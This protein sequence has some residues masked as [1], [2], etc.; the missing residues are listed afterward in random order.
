MRPL[1]PHQQDALKYLRHSNSGALWMQM[2]LGKTLTVVRWVDYLQLR[3]GDRRLSV[4]VVAPM[5]ALPAWEKELRTEG[6]HYLQWLLGTRAQRM[7]TLDVTSGG[8]TLFNKEGFLALPE[9]A[10]YPW[11]VVIID[12][13][14]FLKSPKSKVSKFFCRNF[15]DVPHRCVLSGCPNPESALEFFQQFKFLSGGMMG[16]DNWWSFRSR[17]FKPDYVGY[18]WEPKP[19]A[20]ALI[21]K[22]VADASFVLNREDAGYHIPKVYEQ[23]HLTLPPRLKKSYEKAEEEFVLMLD[24][25]MLDETQWLLKKFTWLRRMCG[26]WVGDTQIWKGKERELLYLLTSELSGQ[27][28]VVWFAFNKELESFHSALTDAGI[29]SAKYRGGRGAAGLRDRRA[30]L[31]KFQLGEARVLLA[32][33]SCAALGMDLSAADTAI[34]ISSPLGRELRSQSEDRILSLQKTKSTLLIIDLVAENSV[35][36]D[37]FT[38]HE[39]KEATG[40]VFLDACR[41]IQDR[42]KR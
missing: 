30:A 2:R 37:I 15:R 32:Q 10:N 12:E 17:L 1:Y 13:S 19:G 35:D 4:L 25:E 26:G 9:V 5:S 21:A 3:A 18:K 8:W 16:H 23:R 33:V 39:N 34:Y 14:T 29:S 20:E 11:D 36:W 22:W 42:R 31:S 41:K 38:L 40:S 7:A 6:G 27:Q 24:D 28:V